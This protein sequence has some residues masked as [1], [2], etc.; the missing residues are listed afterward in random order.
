MVG[1][2]SLQSRHPQAPGAERAYK[3]DLIRGPRIR[4]KSG[5]DE[6]VILQL[7][8]ALDSRDMIDGQSHVGY[9]E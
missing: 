2:A 3:E 1:L 8:D 9:C 7:A 4:I 6:F 5:E